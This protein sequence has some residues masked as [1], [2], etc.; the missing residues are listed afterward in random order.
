MARRKIVEIDESK[1]DGCGQ[2]V[3]SCAEGAIQII[4]GKARLVAD[5]YC[6]GLGACLGQ[7]P[8]DAIRVVER[9]AAN[10]DEG[11]VRQHLARQRSDQ[12]APSHHHGGCPGAA[13]RQFALPLVRPRPSGSGAGAP[14]WADASPAASDKSQLTHW[15]V[16]LH[17]VP[18]GA[19]F[20]RDADVL[21]VAD[22]VPFAMPDFHSRILR[23]RP[24][25]IGCPKLDDGNYYVEK[26]AAM[27][28]ESGLRSLTVVQMEVPCCTGLVRIA[29]AAKALAGVDVPLDTLTVS[30]RGVLL[31][32]QIAA[33]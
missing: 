9:E 15:P 5:V 28:R 26:L 6:D 23:G 2:C 7:C 29:E 16:Q 10:F 13:M 11:A 24:V 33:R 20:L 14:P 18:P 8:Q 21:L 32:P 30:I 31:E 22:C 25:L 4:N 17:L 12:P 3:P 19:A 1:C 27:L